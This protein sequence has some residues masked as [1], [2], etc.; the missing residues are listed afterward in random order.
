M[1]IS[2]GLW[3]LRSAWDVGRGTRCGRADTGAAVSITK[4]KIHT[5]SHKTREGWGTPRSFD[6]AGHSVIAALRVNWW[7]R[8]L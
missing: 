3:S 1:L 6:Q 2:R 4:V 7:R 5:L 8:C